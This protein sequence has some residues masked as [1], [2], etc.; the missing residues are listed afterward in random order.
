M[1][2]ASSAGIKRQPPYYAYATSAYYQFQLIVVMEGVLHCE[3]EAGSAALIPG[4]AALLSVGSAF[5]LSTGAEGYQAVFFVDPA[6]KDALFHGSVRTPIVSTGLRAV[7]ELMDSEGRLPQAGSRDIMLGL[8]RAL[9]WTLAR[10]ETSGSARSREAD[11]GKQCAERAR[12]ALRMALHSQRG[13]RDILAETGLSYRQISRYFSQA[14]GMSP[15]RWLL[16]LKIKEAQTRL[17]ATDIPVTALAYELGFSSSQHFAARF[18]AETGFS[19]SMY[20]SRARNGTIR[21]G[22][23]SPANQ[24]S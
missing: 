24:K 17:S 8:G 22:G 15:K 5:R 12:E 23:L 7:A 18:A 10:D 13:A 2:A 21:Q 4:R 11:Y 1:E 16:D 20:R 19:P 6:P 9:A 3:S 14:Y